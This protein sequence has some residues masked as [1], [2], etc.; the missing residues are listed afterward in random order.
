VLET[1][2]VIQQ[3]IQISERTLVPQSFLPG[4]T[5]FNDQ[6]HKIVGQESRFSLK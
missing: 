2:N 6:F 3:I 1:L 5:R 4:L